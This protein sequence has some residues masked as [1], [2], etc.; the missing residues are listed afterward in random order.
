[1]IRRARETVGESQAAFGAR[2]DVDQS[3]VHRWE[4]DGPPSRGP[5][6]KALQREVEAILPTDPQPVSR[7]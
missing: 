4:T 3:T 2:F 6:R 7:P 5:A 1:M